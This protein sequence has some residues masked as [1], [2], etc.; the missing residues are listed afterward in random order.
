[1]AADAKE[2]AAQ[3]RLGRR[4]WVA[5]IAARHWFPWILCRAAALSADTQLPPGTTVISRISW[6]PCGPHAPFA[7]FVRLSPA[8]IADEV[9]E[10]RRCRVLG[11]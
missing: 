1:M 9:R 4:P 10:G 11:D 7:E 6:L 5:A 3:R 8:S 2:A